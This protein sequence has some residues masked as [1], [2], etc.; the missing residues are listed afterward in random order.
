[1]IAK[2]H[3]FMKLAHTTAERANCMGRKVGSVLVR[4]DRIISTGYN[5]T[6]EGMLNC[7][8]GGCT[9]C[10]NRD[11]FKS[12]TAYDLCICVHA[13]ANALASAARFGIATDGTTLYCTHQPC[14]SC[15]KELIQ[16]G[17]EK[18]WYMEPWP[19][20]E[21]MQ[22][23]YDAMQARLGSEQLAI[24]DDQSKTK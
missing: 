11:I 5:G 15:S 20:N 23:D 22:N 18:V 12:G 14:F 2:T 19:P 24:E 21:R 7:L 16:A 3:Y 13:E 9:R 17:V 8:D 4:D 10:S 6:P 1:M